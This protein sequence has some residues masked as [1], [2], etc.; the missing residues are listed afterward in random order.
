MDGLGRPLERA[1]ERKV[2]RNVDVLFLGGSLTE[3]RRKPG[4]CVIQPGKQTQ[5]SRLSLSRTRDPY[6]L[7][8]L[9]VLQDYN[10]IISARPRGSLPS[11]LWFSSYVIYM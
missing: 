1:S 2:L 10:V 6:F 11:A 5:G 3:L 9:P 7:D 8:A 4:F